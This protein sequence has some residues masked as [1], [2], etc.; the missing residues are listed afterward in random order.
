MRQDLTPYAFLFYSLT[1]FPQPSSLSGGE[2][3][4]RSPANFF[5]PSWLAL[6]TKGRLPTPLEESPP[7]AAFIFVRTDR[8]ASGSGPQAWTFRWRALADPW[9]RG[10]RPVEPCSNLSRST[11]ECLGASE[12]DVV[13]RVLRMVPV[14]IRTAGVLRIVVPGAPAQNFGLRPSLLPTVI[15][16][17][18]AILAR[19]RVRSEVRAKASLPRR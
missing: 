7:P 16:L 2:G 9:N 3:T 17:R 11:F 6:R 8:L 4:G 19:L 1:L 14:A 10:F 15:S 12:P 13:V 18:Q 5:L